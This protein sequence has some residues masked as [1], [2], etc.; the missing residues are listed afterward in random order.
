MKEGRSVNIELRGI[1]RNG[2]AGMQ[3]D[4]CMDE[5]INLRQEAGTLRP[6]GAY[7][8]LNRDVDM[9]GYD[10]VFVHTTAIWKNYLGVR[11]KE[12]N[13]SLEYFAIDIENS[14]SPITPQY[15]GDC[16]SNDV[17][18]NQAGNI[19]V[20]CG[21]STYF[22]LRYDVKS[23]K[24]IR[25]TNDF[26]GQAEDRILPP[27]LDIRFRV[28]LNTYTP[29]YSSKEIPEPII[30]VCQTAED[31]RKSSED[32]RKECSKLTMQRILRKE[33]EKGR[34][35]GFFKLIYAYELFDG[36]HILQSQ[37]ILMPQAND[38]CVRWSSGNLNYLTD[39]VVWYQSFLYGLEA[40]WNEVRIRNYG[41]QGWTEHYE[42]DNNIYYRP[43]APSRSI[44]YS[45]AQKF[46]GIDYTHNLFCCIGLDDEQLKRDMSHYTHLCVS[47]S[48]RLQYKIKSGISSE[49]KDVFK[50]VSVFITREVYGY[51]TG[52]NPNRSHIEADDY[53][54]ENYI[55][56][57]K[58]DVDIIK[59]LEANSVYYKVANISFD[60]LQSPTKE[61]VD[62][63][64]E[65][66]KILANL[67][68][69][70]R[71]RVSED[72]RKSYMPKTSFTYNGRLH[73]AD[74]RNIAF[75]GFP[76]NYFYNEEGRGQFETKRN[77]IWRHK[78]DNEIRDEW[79]VRNFPMISVEVDIRT[80]LR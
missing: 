41:S 25:I 22:C 46:A 15:I 64:L 45:L 38:K 20:L 7:S 10:K 16:G 40:V 33:R 59:G 32:E 6:V 36:S 61:W 75:R 69:Q 63:D 28:D 50:G 23:R 54:V 77:I 34:L 51:D 71:L 44:P 47:Y 26:N 27:N 57:P 48:N 67:E 4:G 30:T 21:E 31:A 12:Q 58:T 62:I 24:Y 8:S 39:D 2:S 66:D 56:N 18:F 49:Y 14:I 80:I 9:S 11:G 55:F 76:L 37:P 78:I 5:I 43:V 79:R 53:K 3:T 17:E 35:K 13:Y 19:A 52:S 68:A 74:Y 72:E 70:D 42:G 29:T 73:I 1:S 65:T 60:K